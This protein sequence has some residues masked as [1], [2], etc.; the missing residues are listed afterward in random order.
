MNASPP[1]DVT[2]TR[3]MFSCRNGSFIDI[4]VVKVYDDVIYI[5]EAETLQEIIMHAIH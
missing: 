4:L 3:T 1:C 5:E 2:V